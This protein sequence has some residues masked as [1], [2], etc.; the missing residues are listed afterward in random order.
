MTLLEPTE[1]TGQLKKLNL[2]GMATCL[3][4]RNEEALAN[5][6]T[7]MEFL[8][9]LVQ[10]ELLAKQQ[11]AYERCYKQADF[12]G[13]KLLGNFDFSFN[14][15]INQALIR[16]LATC[17][18]IREKHPV[19]IMGP[20]GTGKTHIAQAIGHCALQQGFAVL[21]TTPSKLSE[22]LQIAKATH[23]YRKKL[24][25]LSKIPL[26]IIDDFGLKPLRS[27]EDENLH[28]LI[29]ERYE[30]TSTLI[31]SNLALKEWQQAFDNQLLGVATI[32][33]LQQQAYVVLLEGKSYRSPQ[34]QS[35]KGGKLLTKENK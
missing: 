25:A 11:R 16:D 27:P 5:Q 9:L 13:K 6:M 3:S 30:Q 26:L 31:T 7:P 1:L 15:K 12:K 21:C 20:C 14:P 35:K 23:T 2:Q 34:T 33:R 10:D 32:D 8:S 28:E 18:F 17:R 19:L 4:A 22:T 24:K 29:A